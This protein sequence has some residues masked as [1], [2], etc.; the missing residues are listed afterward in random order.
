MSVVG[1]HKSG[2]RMLCSAKSYQARIQIF[3]TQK[4]PRTLYLEGIQF[5]SRLDYL[6]IRLTF[7]QIFLNLSRRTPLTVLPKM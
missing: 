3:I 4:G 1:K 2:Y 5:E 6:P 7:L